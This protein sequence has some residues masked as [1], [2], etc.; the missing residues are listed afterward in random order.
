MGIGLGVVLLLLALCSVGC[1]QHVQPLARHGSREQVEQLGFQPL[2][3]PAQNREAWNRICSMRLQRVD[4]APDGKSA[5]LVFPR[6]FMWDHNAS[7]AAQQAADTQPGGQQ[8]IYTSYN[9][10]HWPGEADVLWLDLTDPLQSRGLFLGLHGRASAKANFPS[11]TVTYVVADPSGAPNFYSVRVD[12]GTSAALRTPPAPEAP[13]LPSGWTPP[14]GRVAKSFADAS[15]PT[16]TWVWIEPVAGSMSGT[17]RKETSLVP[18]EL[19]LLQGDSR[20]P[21]ARVV[22]GSLPFASV[23][24]DA[25]HQRAF[26]ALDHAGVVMADFSGGNTGE[27]SWLLRDSGSRLFLLPQAN[28][29]LVQRPGTI[30]TI[31][32]DELAKLAPRLSASAQLGRDDARRL[33]PAMEGLGWDWGAVQLSPLADRPG[34]LAFLDSSDM[35]STTAELTWSAGSGRALELV[36]TRRPRDLDDDLRETTA[37]ERGK[38]VHDLLVL[39]G[40]PHASRLQS[41]SLEEATPHEIREEWALEPDV[42]AP[43]VPGRFSLWLTPE[44]AVW[45]LH[46]AT[47]ALPKGVLTVEAARANAVAALQAEQHSRLK[48]LHAG[49]PM[50]DSDERL[51][52]AASDS[53]FAS[54]QAR[55]G[56]QNAA[57]TVGTE[58]EPES[59]DNSTPMYLFDVVIIDT[60]EPIAYLAAVQA[61]G[62][63]A[64][65]EPLRTSASELR[66]RIFDGEF[67]PEAS[68]KLNALDPA[69]AAPGAEASGPSNPVSMRPEQ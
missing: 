50:R 19:L 69:A 15:D 64:G 59:F 12:D 36:M 10:P 65:V 28:K 43:R 62:G 13:A 34:R 18:G 55:S 52:R 41:A 47:D 29:L 56:W 39:L 26:L 61:Y 48:P 2:F 60:P 42:K 53:L 40:W 44:A 66:R 6:Q 63:P 67:G 16:A 51:A 57:G 49:I 21:A 7:A 11:R 31:G 68:A 45:E 22:T 33:K 8:A 27:A 3:D 17:G 4:I 35:E 14:A 58:L 20:E 5:L 46:A 38:R 9:P 54:T 30:S 24:G 23:V 1:Q 32:L 37:D 25:A